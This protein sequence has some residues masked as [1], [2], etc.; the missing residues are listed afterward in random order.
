MTS[1][2]LCSLGIF[3]L[4][5][6]FPMTILAERRYMSGHHHH[7]SEKALAATILWPFWLSGQAS[8]R[9]VRGIGNTWKSVRGGVRR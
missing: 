1:I 2:T 7:G 3:Y 6:S 9:M 4:L 8:L 5:I